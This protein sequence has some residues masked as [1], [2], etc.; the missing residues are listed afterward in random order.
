YA[1]RGAG[2][3]VPPRPAAARVDPS[4]DRPDERGRRGLR[5]LTACGRRWRRTGSRWLGV[6][7]APA[8]ARRPRA[9]GARL[10]GA[11]GGLGTGGLPGCRDP[12]PA[13]LAACA[14]PRDPV[15]ALLPGRVRERRPA[16]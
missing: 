13:G 1:V 10:P 7:P 9:H 11:A 8:R 3:A 6:H 4:R 5:T 14:G 15:A 12:V 2:T 16:P